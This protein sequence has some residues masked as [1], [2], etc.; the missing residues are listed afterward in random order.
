LAQ[1]PPIQKGQKMLGLFG[2]KEAPK[3]VVTEE[4]KKFEITQTKP[5]LFVD[6]LQ[7]RRLAAKDAFT[8]VTFNT[9]EAKT[10]VANK[11]DQPQWNQR[12]VFEVKEGEV[13]T[14][15]IF[16]Y[17]VSK[18]QILG[19]VTFSIKSLIAENVRYNSSSIR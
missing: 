15:S 6:I 4:F 16:I 2:K 17:V 11:T 13:E 14:S 7:G 5:L 10:S 19:Q 8:K 12:F 1:F 9:I 3:Q 18:K